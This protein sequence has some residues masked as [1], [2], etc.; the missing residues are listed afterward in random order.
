MVAGPEAVLSLRDVAGATVEE[1]LDSSAW[2]AMALV[3][4]A[5]AEAAGRAARKQ[6]GSA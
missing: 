3:R 6:A 4:D 2:A 1:A 5:R